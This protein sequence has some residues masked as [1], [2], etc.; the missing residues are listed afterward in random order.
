MGLGMQEIRT[1]LYA[2]DEHASQVNIFFCQV[3]VLTATV[4]LR[5]KAAVYEIATKLGVRLNLASVL[6]WRPTQF[7]VRP[8][9]AY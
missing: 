7:G 9:L 5:E 8:N 1:N 2:I 4:N 3:V 6:T